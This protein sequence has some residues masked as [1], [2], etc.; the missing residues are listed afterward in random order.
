MTREQLKIEIAIDENLALANALDEAARW[1]KWDSAAA[2]VCPAVQDL[3]ESLFMKR[4]PAFQMLMTVFTVVIPLSYLAWR[5]HEIPTADQAAVVGTFLV[6]N[7]AFFRA[8][9]MDPGEVV[10]AFGDLAGDAMDGAGGVLV[11]AGDVA[12][13]LAENAGETVSGALG[14]LGDAV[15][16]LDA[17]GIAHGLGEVMHSAGDALA[18]VGGNIANAAGNVINNA[19]D[20]LGNVGDAIGNVGEGMGGALQAVGDLVG[21][22]AGGVGDIVN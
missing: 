10:G 12:A 5:G 4:N 13:G 21:E 15:S 17:G 19:P 8:A 11:S 7:S 14:H 16:N 9:L 22:V 2:R 3:I 1:V 20:M 18:N 6:S